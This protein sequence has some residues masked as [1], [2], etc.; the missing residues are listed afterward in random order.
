MLVVAP[1][2]KSWRICRAFSS[3]VP[4]RRMTSGTGSGEA[5]SPAVVDWNGD[6]VP[7]FVGGAEDG[8]LYY[9][10]NPRSK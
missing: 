7:D 5:V 3:L 8:H 1:S 4:V 2:P 9:L 6:G 10:R